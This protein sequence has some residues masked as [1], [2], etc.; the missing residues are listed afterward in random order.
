MQVCPRFFFAGPAVGEGVGAAPRAASFE[1]V[2]WRLS[3]FHEFY[4]SLLSCV[5]LSSN[6]IDVVELSFQ[7]KTQSKGNCC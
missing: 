4:H 3:T 2:P 6:S 7:N 1:A 5:E